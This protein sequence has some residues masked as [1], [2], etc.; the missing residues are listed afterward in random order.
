MF[1][2]FINKGLPM[3]LLLLILAVVQGYAIRAFA[4]E[5][6]PRVTVEQVR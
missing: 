1:K 3:S 5:V 2:N 4:V 6:T